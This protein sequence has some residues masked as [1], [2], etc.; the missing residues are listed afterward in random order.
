M[1]MDKQTFYKFKDFTVK[2]KQNIKE[3]YF[4][5]KNNRLEQE[6]IPFDYIN[7]ENL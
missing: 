7:K 2:S 5:I 4:G 1:L 3:L 6:K